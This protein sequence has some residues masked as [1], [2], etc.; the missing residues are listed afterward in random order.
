[1]RM[2]KSIVSATDLSALTDQMAFLRPEILKWCCEK[3]S[4]LVIVDSIT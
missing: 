2:L 1:M 4:S 3:L